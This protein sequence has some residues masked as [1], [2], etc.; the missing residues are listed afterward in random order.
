MVD[1]GGLLD[2]QELFDTLSCEEGP[3]RSG[4]LHIA[5]LRSEGY[6]CPCTLVSWK[7]KSM[8]IS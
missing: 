5:R 4:A 3:G 7:K 8:P 6:R 1:S 2:C